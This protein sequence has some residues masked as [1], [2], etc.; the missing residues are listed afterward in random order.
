[1]TI[2]KT[3]EILDILRQH[4]EALTN[5]LV[6]TKEFE[7]HADSSRFTSLL[8]QKHELAVAGT[9]TVLAETAMILSAS[10]FPVH[11]AGHTQNFSFNIK[12]LDD[13]MEEGDYEEDDEDDNVEGGDTP[14]DG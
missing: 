6:V 1:M 14:I 13:C 10:G 8:N 9:H 5:L 3:N 11:T 7:D 2:S 4:Q 12:D